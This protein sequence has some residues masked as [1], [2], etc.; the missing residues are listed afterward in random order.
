MALPNI[1]NWPLHHLILVCQALGASSKSVYLVHLFIRVLR[2]VG[3]SNVGLTSVG[4]M[5][6]V[7]VKMSK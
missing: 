2:E 4:Q 7:K 5:T 3:Q 1:A 6:N